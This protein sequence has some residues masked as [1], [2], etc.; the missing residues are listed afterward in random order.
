MHARGEPP[1]RALRRSSASA[2]TAGAGLVSQRA[3]RCGSVAAPPTPRLRRARARS[4]ARRRSPSPWPPA[5]RRG[6]CAT[7]STRSSQGWSTVPP[8]VRIA[9][10]PARRD[11]TDRLPCREPRFEDKRIEWGAERCYRVRAVETTD[12]LTRR[13]RPSRRGMRHPPTRF[14][15]RR[16][17]GFETGS[18]RGRDQPDLG[19]RHREGSGRL[20][21]AARR[22][23]AA[24]LTPITPAPI[25]E[26]SFT[27]TVPPG[28]RYVYAV[29]AVDKAEQRQ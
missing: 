26:T 16:L 2:G 28:R 7:T 29:Q 24:T 25:Q 3:A 11:S 18:S 23:A 4:H 21:R 5:T 27:D 22:A 6:R 8:A 1:L 14:R 13:E 19:A 15:R 12:G 17:A 10:R 20:L 9:D